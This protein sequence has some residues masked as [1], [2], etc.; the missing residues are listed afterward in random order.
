MV[1]TV[2]KETFE[3]DRA[4]LAG[5]LDGDGAIMASIEK[6]QEKRFGFRVRII[7]KISQRDS[8]NLVWFCDR[9]KMGR[10]CDNGRSFDWIIKNQNDCALLLNKITLYLKAKHRQAKI[11]QKI[12]ETNSN[13]DSREKFLEIARLA[14]SLSALNV[15]SQSRRLNYATMVEEA[16]SRND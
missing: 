8:N 12:L 10:I 11:A 7:I 14:D 4:Y 1:N 13:V 15:R 2:G 16:F 6:H 3:V 5:F 9:F